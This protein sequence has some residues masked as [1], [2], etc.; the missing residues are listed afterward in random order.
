MRAVTGYGFLKRAG[1]S[2]EVKGTPVGTSAEQ[3]LFILPWK[4]PWAWGDGCYHRR[5]RLALKMA[6]FS[7]HGGLVKGPRNRGINS[8]MDGIELQY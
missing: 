7:R 1:S 3:D 4:K 5:S 2:R 8:R 6:K